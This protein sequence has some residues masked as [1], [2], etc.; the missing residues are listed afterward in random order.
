MAGSIM[1]LKNKLPCS[2]CVKVFYRCLTGGTSGEFIDY[3]RRKVKSGSVFLA[4]AGQKTCA[5]HYVPH[6]LS[7]GAACVL[8]DCI[9]SEIGKKIEATAR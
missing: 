2:P 8:V 6:A 5:E 4:V 3:G 1:C 7:Q 9:R